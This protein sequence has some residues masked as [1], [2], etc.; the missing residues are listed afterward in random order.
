[1]NLSEKIGYNFKNEKLINSL[2]EKQDKNDSPTYAGDK[3]FFHP[4]I[5]GA[6]VPY[7]SIDPQETYEA[8]SVR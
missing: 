8:N 6:F 4:I 2:Q 3:T 1:M 7:L 5:E